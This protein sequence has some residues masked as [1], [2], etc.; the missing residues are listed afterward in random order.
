[1]FSSHLFLYELSISTRLKNAEKR[2]IRR[3]WNYRDIFEDRPHQKEI[4][5]D[6][7]RFKVVIAGRRWGKTVLGT[8]WLIKKAIESDEGLCWALAQNLATVK[9]YYLRPIK[10]RLKY[11]GFNVSQDKDKEFDC[12]IKYGNAPEIRIKNKFGNWSTIEFMSYNQDDAIVGRGLD[13]LLLDEFRFM[14]KPEIFQEHLFPCLTDRH[15]ELLIISTPHGRDNLYNLYWLGNKKE[16]P[17]SDTSWK[18]W[19]F[20][21][22]DN[23]YIKDEIEEVKRTMPNDKFRQEFLCEFDVVQDRVYNE[24]DYLTHVKKLKLDDSLPLN[25]SWDFNKRIMTTTISQI[26]DGKKEPYLNEKGKLIEEQDKVIHALYSFNTT[27]DTNTQRHCKQLLQWLQEK[28]WTNDIIMYGDATGKMGSANSNSSSWTIIENMFSHI[29]NV[30]YA[31]E[32][33]N[34]LRE[35]RV[36]AVNAKL[37]NVENKIGIFLDED[38]CQPLIKDFEQVDRDK[39][40]KIRKEYWEKLDYNHNADN[41]GYMVEVEFPVN[42]EDLSDVWINSNMF[43]N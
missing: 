8:E 9:K 17:K 30:F 25:I 20:T 23:Q 21:S 34:P 3:W 27:G 40:G 32:N 5:L 29:P 39:S 7:R 26:V 12:E 36:D 6:K 37:K 4:F 16:N 14:K 28:N 15:G 31:N 11:L 33:S 1:M 42:I 19:L 43:V 41:F 22:Y 2:D 24:F 10:E 18:S 13:A 38:N 35:D